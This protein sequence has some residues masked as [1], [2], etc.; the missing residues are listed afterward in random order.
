MNHIPVAPGPSQTSDSLLH[1]LAGPSITKAGFGLF[2]ARSWTTGS[3]HAWTPRLAKDQTEINRVIAEASKGFK[4]Y[5]V[6]MTN[7]RDGSLLRFF[8]YI[9]NEKRKDKDLTERIGRILKQRDEA[10]KG[11]DLGPCVPSSLS[12]SS[13]MHGS[14]SPC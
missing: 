1:R 5:E 8:L 6:G 14:H 9:Q 3:Y 2:S 7:L 12:N 10:R 4:F 13:L 11:A